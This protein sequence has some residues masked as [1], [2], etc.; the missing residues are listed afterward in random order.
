MSTRRLGS[1]QSFGP[2]TLRQRR[3]GGW[4]VAWELEWEF[5][6]VMDALEFQGVLMGY[7]RATGSYRVSVKI[8]P[9]RKHSKAAKP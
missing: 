5:A 7:E 2:I 9:E 3:S 1:L 6:E 8:E 4:A